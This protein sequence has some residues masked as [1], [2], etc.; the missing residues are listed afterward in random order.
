MITVDFSRLDLLSIPGDSEF[1]ILDI[2]C[3]QGRHVCEAIRYKQVMAVGADLNVDDLRVSMGKLGFQENVGEAVGKWAIAAADITNLPFRDNYFDTVVCSEILEHVPDHETAIREAVRVLKPG[4]DLVVSVPRHF[5]ERI[6]WFLSKTY[7]NTPGGHI[8]I[9][10]KNEII[11]LVENAGTKKYRLHYAH[12]L[13][14][15]YWWLKCLIGPDREDSAA[16]NLY[17]RFLVWDIMKHPRFTRILE[18]WLNP[19]LGKSVVVYFKKP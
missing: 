16:V 12:A 11:S 18:K 15:P 14:T 4:A 8:R 3:G 19:M 6:C 2:G 1:R 5:P 9:Y 13:H 17:N 10:K 7:R